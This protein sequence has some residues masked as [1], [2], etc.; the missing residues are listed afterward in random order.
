MMLYLDYPKI[1]ANA[2][3]RRGGRGLP[4]RTVA[5]AETVLTDTEW[6]LTEGW[7]IPGILRRRSRSRPCSRSSALR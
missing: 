1:R 5:A 4:S 7:L 6:E 2:G 3:G